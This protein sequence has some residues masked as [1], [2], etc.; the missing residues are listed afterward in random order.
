MDRWYCSHCGDLIG[1]Y[2]PAR[3]IL[4]DGSDLKGSVLTLGFELQPPGSSLVHER[5]Y[6]ARQNG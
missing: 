3:V 1:V 4:E 6:A 5:C 2:E